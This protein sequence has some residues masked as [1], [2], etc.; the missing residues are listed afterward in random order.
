[1]ASRDERRRRVFEFIEI[2]LEALGRASVR[3]AGRVVAAVLLITGAL[4]GGL[5]RLEIDTT[6]EG[7]LLPG[8][9]TRVAYREFRETFGSD[10]RIVIAVHASDVL[11]ANTLSRIRTLHDRLEQAVPHLDEITSLVNAR[12]TRSR[13]D[14]LVVGEL[15][16]E[17]P[18]SEADYAA[19]RRRVDANDLYEN[20]L[21]STDRRR[22]TIAL[23]LVPFVVEDDL[24]DGFDV[25]GAEAGGEWGSSPESVAASGLGGEE[26]RAAIDS[27]Q[28]IVAAARADG[29][30]ISIGGS[31]AQQSETTA[32][33]RR[34]IRRFGAMGLSVAILLLG[35]FFRRPAGVLLPLAVVGLALLGTLGAMG[36][37]G[38]PFQVPTQILPNLLFAVGIANAVHLLVLFFDRFDA[39]VP[40]EEAVAY[41]MRH[42][43]AAIALT[44][45]TTAGA[46]VS[47][48]HVPL[49]PIA[50]LGAIAPA[51]VL[52]CLVYTLVLLPALL[53][54]VPMR[55]R[56]AS[57][58][59]KGRRAGAWVAA[60]VGASRHPGIVLLVTAVLMSVAA[61][62]V[63]RLRFSHDPLS[64]LP[65]DHP[66]V[67]ATH[68][69]DAG[70]RGSIFLEALIDGGEV[71]A[72]KD[73]DRLA[74]LDTAR[75][76]LE[77]LE[78]GDFFVGKATSLA[79]VVAEIHGALNPGASASNRLPDERDLVAQELLLFENAGSDDLE[80][81]ADS[82]F[83]TARLTVKAPSRDAV[84]YRPFLDRVESLLAETLGPDVEVQLTGRIP[85]LSRTVDRLVHGMA[86]SY[87]VAFAVIVPWMVLLLGSIRLGLVSMIPNI[88]PIFGTLGVMGF[89]GIPLDGFTLL[90]GCIG[91]GLAV[92]DTIHF[93]HRFQRE[94]DVHR[95]V[96]RAVHATLASTGRA[97]LFT[98]I[99][100]C[101]A[102]ALFLG[103][104]ISAVFR[105]GLLTI[106]ALVL[107]L[108]ADVL[109]APALV[110]LVHGRPAGVRARPGPDA[111]W[112]HPVSAVRTNAGWLTAD[113]PT[114]T[115][116][117][118]STLGDIG[119][120]DATS[121]S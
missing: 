83:R 53:G 2:R 71:G 72:F 48:A 108:A 21:V 27:I 46:F 41:A 22:A 58:H 104:E 52:V 115:R 13:G 26:I 31:L 69:I 50:N 68:E 61:V 92:D 66:L 97:L 116:S 75:S 117:A 44:A 40:R 109:V 93:M 55:R 1:M 59:A 99:V 87:L 88:A 16:A 43:G 45:A 17:W 91:I 78:I 30:E 95:D 24:L 42:S 101:S 57:G 63:S 102:F 54:R 90:I 70:L 11:A 56:E 94:H 29:F 36:W 86:R 49:S 38:L 23:R 113:A 6:Q 4:L 89:A 67:T 74:R 39:G 19:L 103:G 119:Y 84:A 82:E 112:D 114:A 33:M 3:H 96:A 118:N 10:E 80:D 76:R 32:M 28:R 60:G 25:E 47:F 120:A 7:F 65:P 81:F 111:G 110:S 35:V 85:L 79:D 37:L 12:E 73:P 105:F 100:L 62:G 121:S 64:W 20:L 18:E 5:G 8:D 15:L 98:T 51:G 9:P 77:A 106:L 107:A 34:D 14:E